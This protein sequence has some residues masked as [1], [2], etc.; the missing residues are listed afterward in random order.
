[1]EAEPKNRTGGGKRK[2]ENLSSRVMKKAK[3]E[4]AKKR[5]IEFCFFPKKVAKRMGRS[6]QAIDEIISLKKV[7]PKKKGQE[8]GNGSK[9]SWKD[10]K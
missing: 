1:M 7:E 6:F 2:K 9:S 4:K 5:K 8:R 10:R 3:G